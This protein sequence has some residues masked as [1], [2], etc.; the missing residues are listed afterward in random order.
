MSTI[1]W[2]E[3]S[4][5]GYIFWK[6]LFGVIDDKI[7]VESKKG[8]SQLR[9]A[10]SQID[11]DSN[12]YIIV[13][14]SAFDN[15]YVL[16]EVNRI[17]AYIANKQNAIILPVISFEYVLLSFKYLIDWIFA[18]NDDLKHQRIHIV[19]A[20]ELFLQKIEYGNSTDI[21]PL[22]QSL[23]EEHNIEQTASILL[24]DITKNTGFETNKSKLGDCFVIDCCEWSNR[25]SDDICGLDYNRLTLLEKMKS[26]V[27]HSVLNESF[28]G[29]ML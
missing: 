26:I 25:S 1:V 27:K 6:T 15:P 7:V 8:V 2:C 13:V 16:A 12:R 9:K 14:D 23:E 17:K 3:D 10:V 20:I 19:E 29:G 18:E 28:V 4:K 21:S 5:S 22:L 24:K 11:D